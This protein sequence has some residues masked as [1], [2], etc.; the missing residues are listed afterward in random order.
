MHTQKIK[1]K[2]VSTSVIVTETIQLIT[3]TFK[4][5]HDSPDKL[6][7]IIPCVKTGKIFY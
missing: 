7:E 5:I 2:I 6:R 1:N 3:I 4:G